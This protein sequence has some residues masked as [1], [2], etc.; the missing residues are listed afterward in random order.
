MRIG[1]VLC[2]NPLDRITRRDQRR[3]PA[4][5]RIVLLRILA[6]HDRPIADEFRNVLWDTL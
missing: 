3:E 5:K 1:D 4:E 2:P 6:L